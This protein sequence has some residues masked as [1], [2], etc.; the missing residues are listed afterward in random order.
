MSRKLAIVTGS[1]Q[2]IGLQIVKNLCSTFD[3]DVLLTSR[4]EARGLE[5]MKGVNASNCKFH[6]L[7]ITN[8]GSIENLKTFVE[9]QYP[10]A[11]KILVNNAGI[12][13]KQNATDSFDVQAKVTFETNYFG[14][15][16]L[17]RA[18]FPFLQDHARIVNVS[19]RVGNIKHVL[20]AKIH[21]KILSPN[22]KMDE[23][24]SLMQE[25]V[26]DAAKGDSAMN[27]KWAKTAYGMSKVGVTFMTRVLQNEV[28]AEAKLRDV[29]VN[30]CCPG[31]IGTNMTSHKG[32][33]TLEQGADT[34]CYLAL[35]PNDDASN[36]KGRFVADRKIL[37][38]TGEEWSF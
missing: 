9:T 16:N 21:E 19:S 36:P 37:S 5:A 38:F 25:F 10:G 34:P 6:Q 11:L 27:G 24:T 32:P 12:A 17:C 22:L 15:L 28:D 8:S 33:G 29:L 13:F 18:L 26:A 14:T 35:L 4:N 1:N 2:G 3:G 20:D 7:D 30:S 31:Y 23:L